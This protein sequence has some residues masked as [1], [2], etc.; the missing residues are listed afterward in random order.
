[1]SSNVSLLSTSSSYV[2]FWNISLQEWNKTA[3]D[4]YLSLPLGSVVPRDRLMC[5]FRLD[6]LPKGFQVKDSIGRIS[7]SLE[8]I[9]PDRP[10]NSLEQIQIEM[11]YRFRHNNCDW[12][13]D[14]FKILLLLP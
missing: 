6:V 11:A 9:Y 12:P 13:M 7:L 8:D 4:E 10:D 14:I 5:Q 3:E 1:M 2:V